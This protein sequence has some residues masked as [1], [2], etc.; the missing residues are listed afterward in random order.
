MEQIS[1][2]VDVNYCI[3]HKVPIFYEYLLHKRT[4]KLQKTYKYAW[5][6]LWIPTQ[7]YTSMFVITEY[8]NANSN[9]MIRM[10]HLTCL[11]LNLTLLIVFD[12]FIRQLT[13]LNDTKQL[14]ENANKREIFLTNG[15]FEDGIE[16][17]TNVSLQRELLLLSAFA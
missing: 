13:L 17:Q 12:V 14:I 11:Y 6:V 3:N 2:K 15:S 10:T 7:G 1:L 8:N 5:E 9:P 16:I 4:L